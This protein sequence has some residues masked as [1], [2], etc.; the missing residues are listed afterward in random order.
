MTK[1]DTRVVGPFSDCDE[2]S[3]VPRQ[4][5]GLMDS[6]YPWQRK[7][8][9]SAKVF[10]ARVINGIYDR[11]GNNGKSTVASLMELFEKGVDLPPVNDAQK[12]IQSMCDVCMAKEERKSSPVFIDMP[13]AMEKE[14]AEALK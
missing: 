10:D 14:D 8:A 7:V 12:L 9:D 4:Y 1:L 5:R 2:V 6:L 3:Y 13:C 11:Y